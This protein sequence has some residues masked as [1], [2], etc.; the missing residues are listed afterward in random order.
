[1]MLEGRAAM[2]TIFESHGFG[3]IRP[4]ALS[5][6]VFITADFSRCLQSGCSPFM[7]LEVAREVLRGGPGV[8][9]A[10][11]VRRERDQGLR[12]AYLHGEFLEQPLGEPG[13]GFTWDTFARAVVTAYRGLRIEEFM[14]EAT[15][16]SWQQL[17]LQAGLRPVADHARALGPHPG[18][19]SME[20]PIL[21]LVTRADARRATGSR[22]ADLFIDAK[23]QLG[24]R[25]PHVEL[26]NEA[27][28]GLTDEE[29][30]DALCLS[31]SAVKK[32]WQALYDHLDSVAP[33]LLGSSEPFR[34]VRGTE[35]R[36]RLLA[37]LREHPEELQRWALT[38]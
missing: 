4:V 1:M 34:P 26:A 14:T 30:S 6:S 25:R 32:R 23:P 16:E 38:G 22:I 36:R 18:P 5:M 21:F 7:A 24:L 27:L 28:D 10:S 31:L 37:Y 2:F 35:R 29:I 3:E 19:A 17:L 33:G 20:R 8:L 9:D 11:A 13:D 12:I 15:S